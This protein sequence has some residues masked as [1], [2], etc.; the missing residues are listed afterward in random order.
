MALTVKK[1]SFWRSEV[2]N[3]PGILARVLGPLARQI[4]I[5]RC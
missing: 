1:I 2:N 3:K 5:S 4:P